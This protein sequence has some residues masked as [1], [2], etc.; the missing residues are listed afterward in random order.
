MVTQNTLPT[1]EGNPDFPEIDFII[2]TALDINKC[3]TQIKLPVSNPTSAPIFELPPY[4]STMILSVSVKQG[5]KRK[6]YRQIIL[7]LDL[8]TLLILK[9]LPYSVGTA[10]VSPKRQQ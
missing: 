10:F 6:G 9:V 7:T 2:A 8:F 4:I 5:R 3:F 1:S